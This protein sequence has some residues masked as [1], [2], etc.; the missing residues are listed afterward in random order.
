MHHNSGPSKYLGPEL[1]GLNIC[2]SCPLHILLSQV[3]CL[4][5]PPVARSCLFV[6]PRSRDLL[7]SRE[8]GPENVRMTPAPCGDIL[9]SYAD[10][11]R[12]TPFE[13]M[14]RGSAVSVAAEAC[15]ASGLSPVLKH[16]PSG[17]RSNSFYSLNVPSMTD[18]Q[19]T[20]NVRCTA[21]DSGKEK[22]SLLTTMA[23]APKAY[24]QRIGDIITSC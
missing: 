12:T 5:Q 10:L 9:H 22:A 20:E 18:N 3:S 4:S 7:K 24:H 6:K 11:C 19:P 17:S 13:T 15:R 16:A 1:P 2:G 14:T 23:Q 21:H 8:K